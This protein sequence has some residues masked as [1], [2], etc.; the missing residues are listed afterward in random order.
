MTTQCPK[1]KEENT[2][3][4]RFCSNCATPLLFSEEPVP[5]QT[6]EVPKEELTTGYTFAGRYQIIEEL[7][8]GGMGKVYKV[9][10]KEVKA[11]IALKLIKPE[12]ASDKKTIERFRNELKTARDI[13]HKNVCHMYDLNK[14]EGSYYITMEYVSGEDLKSL[15]RRVKRFD[16]GTA[17]SIAKQIC[18]GLAEA[19]TLGVVHR[20]LKPNNIMIDR[21]GNAKIMDFGIARAVK[22]KSITGSGVMIGT[23]QYMSPEQVEGKEVD[24]RSDIYSLGIILYEMLT[25]R[26]PFEGDT[27]LTV[28]VKQKTEIPKDPKDF[29]ERIPDDLNQLILK[30]LKKEK[31]NRYQSAKELKSDL[32]KLEQG[33]PTTE[34]AEPK[35]KPLTS[36]EITVRF[37]LKKLML[38]ILIAVALLMSVLLILFI[39]PTKKATSIAILPFE[40]LSPQKDQGSLCEGLASSIIKLLTQL[41]N[42]RVPPRGSSFSFKDKD[43]NYK[44]IASKLDVKFILDGTLHKEGDSIRLYAEITDVNSNSAIWSEQYNREMSDIFTVQDEIARQIVEKLKIKLLGDKED[45]VFKRYTENSKAFELYSQGTYLV[46]RRGADRMAKAI[47]CFK[48]AIAEDSDYALAY[49]GLADAFV[50]QGELGYR[51]SSEAYQE[52]KTYALRALELDSSLAEAHNTLGIFYHQYDWEWE[53]AEEEFKKAIELNPNYAYAHMEYGEFLTRQ[54]RFEEARHEMKRAVELNPHSLTTLAIANGWFNIQAQRYD[55]AIE[56]MQKVLQMDPDNGYGKSYLRAA[57]INKGNYEE[58][59]AHFERI[60]DSHSIA[61]IKALEGSFK[62][63][64]DYIAFVK[65]SNDPDFRSYEVARLYFLQGKND[66]GF[67]WLERALKSKQRRMCYI[68]IDQDFDSVRSDPHFQEILKKIGLDK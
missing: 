34:R 32:E 62:E 59:L 29:N 17:I 57:Q 41:E 13:A 16:I 1:C 37:N 51:I 66:E 22:G 33:L 55:E 35:T 39:L 58:A 60:N 42:L 18:D 19:H 52:A 15:V 63:A 50:H 12:I 14:E 30:C 61:Y 53:K 6:L 5:T 64:E 67:L 40:D 47:E 65:N 38:P 49:A 43:K 4:A 26:V 9:L 56:Q 28:G 23:P 45:Q 24:P 25:A 11:K 68:G 7:G 2:D 48:A 27:P 54:S 3:A 8:R 36:R 31:E 44:D 46:D 21:G 20:D 10:D